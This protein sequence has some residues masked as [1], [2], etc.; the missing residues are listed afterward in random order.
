MP[1]SNG[2]EVTSVRGTVRALLIQIN[3]R[4][5]KLRGFDEE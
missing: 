4:R 2:F 1:G 5:V 3:E